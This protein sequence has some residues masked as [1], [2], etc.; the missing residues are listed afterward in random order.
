[1]EEKKLIIGINTKTGREVSLD[2]NKLMKGRGLVMASAGAGKSYTLRKIIEVTY[3]E[4]KQIIFDIEGE[5]M[6]LR[7]KYQYLVFGKDGDIEIK[8]ENAEKICQTILEGDDSVIINLSDIKIRADKITFVEE[9]LNYLMDVPKELWQ[10]ILLFLDEAHRY[11][12]EIGKADSKDAVIRL[13]DSGRKKGFCTILSTQRSAKL[14]KDAA[15]ETQN[16]FIGRTVLD[17]DMKRSGDELGFINKKQFLSLRDLKDGEFYC[18]GPAIS[19]K[20]I[21]IKIGEVETTHPE[22]VL[23]KR[24]KQSNIPHTKI[25]EKEEKHLNKKIKINIIYLVLGFVFMMIGGIIAIPGIFLFLLGL[26]QIFKT[27]MEKK[28]NG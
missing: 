2:L 18:Y 3:K 6:T 19:N 26:Y 10:P 9:F 1:M 25:E 15:A 11:C 14:D 24:I 7:E 21:K 4:V 23:E 12:P 5:F 16:R 22:P 28:L 17:I 8:I 27:R 20:V 13:M